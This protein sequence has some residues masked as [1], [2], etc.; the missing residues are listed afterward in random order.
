MP[1]ILQ[2]KAYELWLDPAVQ[3]AAG[4][5]PLLQPFPSQ[6]LTAYPV[7]TRVNNPAN[8]TPECIEPLP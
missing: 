5:Q 4:L 8:D 6:E 7:S 1:V 2:P 3:D